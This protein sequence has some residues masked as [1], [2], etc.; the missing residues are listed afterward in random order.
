MN[1]TDWERHGA[2]DPTFIADMVDDF[3]PSI[4]DGIDMG[5]LIR[6]GETLFSFGTFHGF[7]D[8]YRPVAWRSSDGARWEFI[9]SESAFYGYGAV[10]D[11]ETFEDGLLAARAT[12]LIG[13]AYDLW[14]WNSDSSWRETGIRSA[15][16]AI[17]VSLDAA[18]ID[19]AIVAVGQV[20]ERESLPDIG[21]NRPVAWISSDAEQWDE[22][23]LP[24]EIAFACGVEQ[25]PSGDTAVI[26]Q[27]EGGVVSVWV[28]SDRSTWS[29]SALEP[30]GCDAHPLIRAGD[31][32]VAHVPTETEGSHIWLSRDGEQWSLQEL[33]RLSR[34]RAA[35]LNGTLYVVSADPDGGTASILFHATP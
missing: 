24:P 33:P 17:L 21:A 3:G 20:A 22:F 15:E 9:E 23:A 25:T 6:L 1:G 13:P 2:P 32:L 27:E 11:V 28:T 18:T 14:A 35:E 29:R 5:R 8:F 7:N 16:G 4:G 19:D 26:G 10:N 30:G 12:G 34:V 31:W